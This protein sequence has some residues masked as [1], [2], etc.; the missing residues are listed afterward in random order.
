MVTGP[1][2]RRRVVGT[3]LGRAH[4][5]APATGDATEP[6]YP[7]PPDAIATPREALPRCPSSPSIPPRS[8][9]PRRP[10]GR[11]LRAFRNTAGPA[12]PVDWIPARPARIFEPMTVDSTGR[13]RAIL[14][15]LLA[16]APCAA[17][18]AR[19]QLS[20]GP[21]SRAH[22]DLDGALGC[23]KC[24]GR[25]AGAKDGARCL[26]CHKEIAWLIAARR[27]LHAEAHAESCFDCHA[28][29]GGR[30]APLI[31]FDEG[32]PEK[33]DHARAGFA[34]EGRHRTLACTKCHTPALR[35]GEAAR[36]SRRGTAPGGFVGLERACATCHEDPH[37]GRLGSECRTCHGNDG[38]K[39]APGFDHGKTRFALTGRH[40]TVACAK[41]HEKLWTAAVAAAASGEGRRPRPF[42]PL[43]HEECSACH[44]D[45]HEAR[46]GADCAR[47]HVT[48]GFHL[49]VADAGF[50]H[51]RTG[52]PLAGKH[53]GVACER[54][55]RGG[56]VTAA[57]GA[58]PALPLH[59]RHARCDDCHADAHGAQLTSAGANAGTGAGA[60]RPDCATCHRVD[61]WVPSRFGIAQHA[62]TRF[63]LNGRHAELGCASCHRR[64]TGAEA[65]AAFGR[66]RVPLAGLA[67]ACESCHADPHAGRF[68]KGGA[69]PREQGCVACHDQSVFVPSLVD[70]KAHE[71]FGV[72][73]GGPHAKVK[74]DGCHKELKRTPRASS[75]VKS[76]G[77]ALPFTLPAGD[78]AA[79]HRSPHGAQFVID[80]AS[81]GCGRC[82]APDTF[83]GAGRFDH[84]HGSRFPLLRAHGKTPCLKCHERSTRPDGSLQVVYRPL[85][86]N[87]RE[88]HLRLQVAE[89]RPAPEDAPVNARRRR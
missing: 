33:F 77:P 86:L 88:C 5:T 68:L 20:P 73:I 80:A 55:H 83:K 71:A 82:H 34:L 18:E 72:S 42:G 19:A 52:F 87:C 54:C 10:K 79:C 61:G 85:S 57:E 13:V 63:A 41:C 3:R 75:L 37:A 81:G 89:A 78:C 43:A 60:A 23:M 21:L 56:P 40:A 11:T 4:R 29:H 38:F 2:Q 28:E 15:V 65:E 84:D 51:S 35:K 50:D 6:K 76:E 9:R 26:E 36:L 67:E 12:R 8:A 24:H 62:G 25:G 22:A 48:N 74:C 7:A 1:V 69:H 45:V 70:A 39:P 47:C 49:R 46:L 32:A 59:P 27:G 30:D 64:A 44:R 58:A 14:F 16:L 66:A 53:A 31:R 17:R